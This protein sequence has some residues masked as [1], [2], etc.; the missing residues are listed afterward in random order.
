MQ[1]RELKS[2]R[3][4]DDRIKTPPGA[5]PRVVAALASVRRA[6]PVD[7]RA[8]ENL[9]D[10]TKAVLGIA[11]RL[12]HQGRAREAIETLEQFHAARGAISP[13]VAHRLAVFVAQA[14]DLIR[15]ERYIQLALDAAPENE[16]YQT[17]LK[18]IITRRA[19]RR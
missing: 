19:L 7:A 4:A 9:D 16:E 12:Q 1:E 6:D 10:A 5:N 13:P 11:S 15:A 17:A 8:G 2:E 14:G 3:A 18:V